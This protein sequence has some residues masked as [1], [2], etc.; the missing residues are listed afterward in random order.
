LDHERNSPYNIIIKTINIKNKERILRAARE[1]GK[2]A[3]K[4][5]V[6]DLHLKIKRRFLPTTHQIGLMVKIY[7]K[8]KKAEYQE[9][10]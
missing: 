3:C 4:T 8:L 2:I 1:K 10:K 9:S 5:H 6:L 7:V